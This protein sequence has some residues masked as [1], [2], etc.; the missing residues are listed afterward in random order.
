MDYKIS[1]LI[2]MYN[3]EKYIARC[4]GSLFINTII[5]DCEVIIVDDCSSDNSMSIINTL[6]LQYPKIQHNVFLLSHEVNKGSAGARNTLLQHAHGKYILFVDSDDWVESNYLDELYKK[7]EICNA[8]ITGCDLYSEYPRK[9]IIKE[10]KIDSNQNECINSMLITKTNGWLWLKLIRRDLIEK[11]KIDFVNDINILEDL[12]FSIKCFYYANKTAYVNKPLYHYNHN[13]TSYMGSLTTDIKASNIIQAV[14]YIEDFLKRNNEINLYESVVYLKLHLKKRFL[15]RGT[16]SVQ[17]KYIKQWP[18][19][20]PYVSKMDEGIFYK[21]M[22][23][24][25]FK[26][27]FLVEIILCAYSLFKNLL[28]QK[29]ITLYLN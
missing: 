20:L 1:V 3:A 2:P 11:N 27:S 10:Q 9:S 28:K 22:M 13:D 4:L 23:K 26:N 16:I 5:Q 19:I 15:F 8:D 18:E 7:A 17:K 14:S 6:L 25:A 29:K 12:I 21:M 24:Y